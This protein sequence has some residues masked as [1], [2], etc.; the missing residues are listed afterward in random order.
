MA[1]PKSEIFYNRKREHITFREREWG[2]REGGMERGRLTASML[3]V[4]SRF[5]RERSLWRML[6][7]WR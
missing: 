5:E 7:E 1:R 2:E 4:S 6:C 3:S